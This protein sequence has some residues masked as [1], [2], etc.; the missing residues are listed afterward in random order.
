M[1][2]EG[3]RGLLPQSRGRPGVP[4]H[5][6]VVITETFG[7]AQEASPGTGDRPTT[8]ADQQLAFS[9]AAPQE[10]ARRVPREPER[11]GAVP[12]VVHLYESGVAGPRL[13]NEYIPLLRGAFARR[14][15]IDSACL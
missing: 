14:G 5:R 2:V 3:A 8:V 1:G 9:A 15:L 12:R 10:T 7:K 4:R 11:C 6:R 13:K